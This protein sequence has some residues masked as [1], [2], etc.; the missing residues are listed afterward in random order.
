MESS[1]LLSMQVPRATV[2][3]KFTALFHLDEYIIRFIFIGRTQSIV[4]CINRAVCG[5]IRKH[6]LFLLT[7]VDLS[8]LVAVLGGF[9]N[10]Y[11]VD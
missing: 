1:V 2:A 10:L 3:T 5:G 8:V 11:P 7:S 6:E 9:A 4:I